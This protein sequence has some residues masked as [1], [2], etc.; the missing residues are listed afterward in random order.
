MVHGLSSTGWP[1]VVTR[2]RRPRLKKANSSCRPLF[3]SISYHYSHRVALW[4]L[5]STSVRHIV[6]SV[7]QILMGGRTYRGPPPE[8]ADFS[9]VALVVNKQLVDPLREQV[10]PRVSNEKYQTEQISS[11]RRSTKKERERGRRVYTWKAWI[12]V[13]IREW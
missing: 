2:Y 1:L 3:S 7:E 13:V 10:R 4:L 6:N 8:V 12:I 5:F 9:W 11:E